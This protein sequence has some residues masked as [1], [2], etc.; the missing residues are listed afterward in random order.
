MIILEEPYVSRLLIETVAAMHLPVLE[1]PTS[2]NLDLPDGT[3]LLSDDAFVARV[4][5]ETKTG[6]YRLYTNS[7]QSI[8]WIAEHLGF[9]GL[10]ARI[11]RC[12]DKVKF[13]EMLRPL[14]PDFFYR[15]VPA[16]RLDDL[17]VSA[18]PKP[19]V[20]KPAVG[21]FSAGVYT[22]ATDADWASVLAS[23]THEIDEIRAHY[24]PEVCDSGRFIIEEQ[25][26]GTELAVDAYYTSDGTPVVLDILRHDF[27][28][29]DDVDDKVYV[30]SAAVVRE[31]LGPV[32]RLLKEINTLADLTTFPFHIELRV[33]DDGVMVPIELNPLR[34][35]G[36]CTTDIALHAYGINVYRCFFE[37]RVPD[38]DT[39]LREDAGGNYSLLVVKRPD[40]I[41]PDEIEGFDADRFLATFTRP[42]E[43]RP[44][45]FRRYPVFGFLF[46]ETDEHTRDEIDR[47]LRSDQT[48][49]VMLRA[50]R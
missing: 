23:L 44:I 41:D 1:N 11:D 12:K 50:D 32:L 24:P 20:I 36:W 38:W 9:T 42:L 47:F 48:E 22:V 8:A 16:D 49:F 5:E 25:I 4:R 27:S 3:V 17:D 30:T 40:G 10:P 35:A 7:E 18:L 19:F 37:E 34:F 14:Y 2:K 45:D 33:G 15:E 6:G 26:D 43:W 46:T 13:R 39:I 21:F 29:A 31:Y 28:A